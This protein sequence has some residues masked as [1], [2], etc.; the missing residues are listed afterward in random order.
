[1]RFSVLRTTL[2]KPMI[3]LA[4]IASAG[5]LVRAYSLAGATMTPSA[6]SAISQDK[7]DRPKVV[8]VAPPDG[9]TGI[10]P[11]TEVRIRFDRP[12][13]PT[14][15]VLEWARA[16]AGFRLRGDARYSAD[17]HEFAIPMRLTP[18]V[19]HQVTAGKAHPIRP[20]TFDGFES[21]DHVVA[22][23]FVW[24]FTTAKPVAKDGPPPRMVSVDPPPDT[25]VA[26][27]IRL[28]VTFD[29]PMDPT[30]YGLNSVEPVDP[31][32]HFALIGPADYDPAKRRFS[33][34]VGLPASWNGELALRG[35]RGQDGVEA[36]PIVL[37]YRTG[38]QV[39]ADS[40]QAEF[41]GAGRSAEDL[42]RVVEKVR[43]ARRKLTSVS[44]QARTTGAIGLVSPDWYSRY[45]TE[46]SLR[47]ARRPEIRRRSGRNHGH[48]LPGG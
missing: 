22:E 14:R 25:E 10:D 19:K 48:P 2:R 28:D 45:E 30:S 13:D 6:E 29:R 3:V 44:E 24:S 41:D 37:K 31:G 16:D 26:Q 27:V 5:M 18:G 12:M 33:M 32:R 42:R 39:V 20:G 36:A 4:V 47:D 34:R 35:F 8:Q 43:E 40:L 7:P 21:A 46:G 38:R 15:M 23:P 11:V 9:A 1:M 17:R